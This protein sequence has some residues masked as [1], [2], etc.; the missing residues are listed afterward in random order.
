M[1]KIYFTSDTHFGD[2]RFFFM[3]RPFQNL[4]EMHNK[5]IE[6][7]NSKIDKDD[8]VYHLGDF[9]TD[10]KYLDILKE[11]NGNIHLIAGNH[12]HRIV[13]NKYEDKFASFTPE[14]FGIDMDLINSAGAKLELYLNHYPIKG[15]SDRFNLHGHIHSSYKVQ[16]NS[17]NVGVDV[18]HFSPVSVD[19]IFMLYN[20]I[21][22]YYD[23]D[24]WVSYK[25]CNTDH[26]KRGKKGSYT[27]KIS[28]NN[29][30]L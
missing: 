18:W 24:V 10:D 15:K 17:I 20:A 26:M 1:N 8:E 21:N 13:S 23:E 7:W 9:A 22:S 29:K 2:S 12:D 28:T 25:K 19:D 6:S 14:G 27:E 11:L 5:I 4:D 3:M 30:G 16:K